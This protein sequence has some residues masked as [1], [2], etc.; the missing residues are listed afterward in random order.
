MP[1]PAV[2]LKTEQICRHYGSVSV[3]SNVSLEIGAGE[4]HALAGANGAGK[5]TFC[6]ILSGLVKKTSGQM[7][8]DGVEFDPNGKRDAE[9]RGIEIVQQELNLIPTFTVAENLQLSALPHRWGII[10]RRSLHAEARR[11]LQRVGLSDLCPETMT[12]TLGIGQQQMIEIA[13]AVG[14]ECR[15]LILD[16]PTAAL[17]PREVQLLFAQIEF[18]KARGTS[19]IYI[20]HRLDEIQAIADRVSV[21]RDGRLV[22]SQAVSEVS[23]S[24]MIQLMSGEQ[25]E[26][27]HT[28]TA[29]CSG[30]PIPQQ[31]STARDRPIA[32]RVRHLT[33]SG[34]KNVSF[35]VHSGE[36]LGITGLVGAGRTELLRAIFG[37]D[38]A[39]DGYVQI[40]NDPQ[41]YRFRTPDEAV[42]HG[43][44]M[45]TEDRRASGLLLPVSIEQNS[46][47]A[48]LRIK[49]SSF[50]LL[51][52]RS[53]RVSAETM[54][55]QLDIRCQSPLQ[56]VAQ[57]SGGNQQKVVVSKWLQRDAKIFLFDEPTRGVD[58]T[59][60]K[61]IYDV[62]TL[63]A[64]AGRGVV[65]VS[66]DLEELFE[67]SDRIGV[68]SAGRWTRCF[69]RSDWNRETLM[70]AAFEG[71]RSVDTP[72][73]TSP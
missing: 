67:I 73:P 59:A 38:R 71:Y 36:K 11:L 42:R 18:L 8:I 22:A 64:A 28:V 34:V 20:S 2:R 63:R 53:E 44:A 27:G 13:A 35:D 24:R 33:C 62:I 46:S 48:S 4:V 41:K 16:E 40:E 65:I 25:H 47:L 26:S 15:V 39:E 29:S 69:D 5:S 58:I 68:M 9:Q 6:R 10:R 37:A 72:H 12:G 61:R 30:I 17:S 43:L 7:F 23:T 3:L 14:R 54:I 57:L 32:M 1:L 19:I 49:Y 31:S 56:P 55:R 60:R 66:S 70:A 21:L 51:K 52:F 45:L 50:G